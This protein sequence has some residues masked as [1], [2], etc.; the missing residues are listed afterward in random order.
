MK[1][2]IARISMKNLYTYSGH[3]SFPEGAPS[4]MDIAISLCR[5]GRYAGAGLRWWPVGLH[6][7]V[8][9][10]LLPAGPLKFHGLMHDAGECITGDIPSPVKSKANR[11]FDDWLQQRIYETQGVK[12]PTAEQ[13]RLIK[14][15]DHAALR[16][17]V[18]AGAGTLALQAINKPH[19]RAEALV[20]KYLNEYS[21]GD[22]LEAGGRA[23]IEFMRRFRAYKAYL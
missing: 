10:D 3:I 12:M 8:V 2:E 22:C 19:P 1:N 18:W 11:E 4:I 16:G 9:S 14:V 17:E 21:Y 20:I 23:P 5:E 15:A 7:F 6:S 13:H